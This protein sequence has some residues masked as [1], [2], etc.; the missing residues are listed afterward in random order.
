MTEPFR[1]RC[2]LVAHEA[3]VRGVAADPK[4][5]RIATASRD[6]LALLW[7]VADGTGA[8]VAS[9]KGHDHFVDAVA[10]LPYGSVFTASTD[11]TIRV[12]SIDSAGTAT[13][14]MVLK[15]HEKNV[16]HIQ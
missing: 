5:T 2:E 9:L 1:L 3:D 12:W 11:S 14:S 16:C 15:G 13:S 6:S 10:F 4:S 7:D 8:P